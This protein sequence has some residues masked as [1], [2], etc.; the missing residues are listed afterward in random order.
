MRIDGES[1]ANTAALDALEARVEAV[2]GDGEAVTEHLDDDGAISVTK[3]ITTLDIQEDRFYT[4]APPTVVGQRKV[5]RVIFGAGG[6]A[7]GFLDS[8]SNTGFSKAGDATHPFRNLTFTATD[9]FVELVGD[10]KVG[11]GGWTWVVVTTS[12][13][14][15]M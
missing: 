5:I 13:D 2:M 11:L 9:S 12:G 8:G 15:G 7:V 4:I 1:E 3:P 6:G 14:V 10:Y